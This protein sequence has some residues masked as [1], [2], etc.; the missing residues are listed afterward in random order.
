MEGYRKFCNKLW[1][2]TKFALLKLDDSFVPEPSAK[3]C[4]RGHWDISDCSVKPT[5]RESL[6]EKW[7]LQKLNFAAC[8]INSHLEARNF[9][10]ATSDA[11]NFWLYELC[12]VYIVRIHFLSFPIRQSFVSRKL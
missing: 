6:V 12:D 1:N 11:Y 5:G 9:M 3:V 7:I 8:E 2:A 10:L 4:S